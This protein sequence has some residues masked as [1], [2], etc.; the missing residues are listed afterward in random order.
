MIKTKS[1]AEIK[2][3]VGKL[4]VLLPGLG[5]VATTFIAGTLLVRKGL[6]L[7]IG[8]LTQMGTIRLGKRTERRFP[9]IKEFVPLADLN[10]L[11]FGG[12][13][14]FEDNAY[15]SALKAGVLRKEHLDLVKDELEQIRPMKAVFDKKYVRKLDGPNVKKAKD[16][17]EL[18]QML[19]EDIREFKQK[20]NCDRLVM[21][22][23]GST[24]V[25]M[26]PTEA[27]QTLEKF[28]EA[29]KR[30]DDAIAPSMI[31]AYAAIAEGVPYANGAPN[32]SVDIPALIQFAKEMK[33]PI[34]GKDF[35]TGQTLVKTVIA[36]M[37]KARMLGLTGWFS[38][39]ILGNRD[40][41]VLD[42][43][44]SFKT[45]EVSKLGVLEYIL[46]P[47]LYPDLYGNY[48]HKVRINFY[49]PR[50]DEKEAWDNI[51]IFGWLGYPMQIKINFLCRDSI[52]AAPI[53]LDLALF[54]DL[55]QRSGMSGIQEWLSFYF[56]SPMHAP[57]VYPEHDLFIQL[58]KLKNRLR[59]LMGEELIT[60][61]GLE[62]YD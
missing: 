36:P 46:Q 18:A 24:E 40:G 19:R 43:P 31:Y 6:A 58:M 7:P 59:H 56:K 37:L 62:Y 30:N 1:G 28:E 44:E 3:P 55:A 57:T 22:W 42:D 27:H 15:E 4:G 8:S 21:I 2:E 17:F 20:N 29:M 5:A 53:V 33:V 35:K 54:L 14:I 9:K 48:Y 23:C 13:D 32:L 60:H 25:Y 10:D 51:D 12:W 26:E 45:K 39:N 61:L 47:E 38:V 16:K 41:E 49:P 11:V 52:L 34:A 50:G